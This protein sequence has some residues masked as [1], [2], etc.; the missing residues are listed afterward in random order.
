MATGSAVAFGAAQ[1]ASAATSGPRAAAAGSIVYLK[2]GRVWIAHADGTHARVFTLH[3]FNWSSPS[4]ADNGT[5]VVAGGRAH[6]NPGGTE[7][8]A[9]AEIYRFRPNGNQI[10]GAIPTF[11]TYSSHSCP[12]F[13]PLSVEVSPDATK[14]AYGIWFC[15]GAAYTA[16]WTPVTSTGLNFPH[17]TI[18]QQDFYEPHWIDSSTFLVS[19]AGVTIS[20]SQARWYTH[21]VKQKDDTGFKGWNDSSITSSGAQGLID[22]AGQARRLRGRRRRLDERQAAPRPAVAVRHHRTQDP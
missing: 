22:R 2:G 11:G 16:L 3:G 5:I 12:T 17:Q 19:H 7:A 20:N 9:S 10:G 15:G 18:G 14:I 13:A 8:A 1:P 21:G 4:E 6:T